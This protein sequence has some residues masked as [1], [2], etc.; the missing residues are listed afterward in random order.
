MYL[1]VFR[2]HLFLQDIL[3]LML[4]LWI[5]NHLSSVTLNTRWMEKRRFLLLIINLLNVNVKNFY[6]LILCEVCLCV[7][8]PATAAGGG[9]LFWACPPVHTYIRLYVCGG[10]ISGTPWSSF[11][12]FE[13]EP[14]AD[15]AFGGHVGH[16]SVINDLIM[17][18]FPANLCLDKMMLRHFIS[19]GFTMTSLSSAKKVIQRRNSWTQGEIQII[20]NTEL[21]ETSSV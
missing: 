10:S 5:L 9:I 3:R 11:F 15:L 4:R 1:S 18:W 21:C 20:S 6:P 2:R 7:S 16:N 8:T 12:K 14:K 19:W 17:T 13:L